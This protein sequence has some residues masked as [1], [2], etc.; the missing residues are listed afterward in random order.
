MS[1]AEEARPFISVI[2]PHL[3]QPEFLKSCLASLAR[4]TYQRCS[5]EVVVV[6]NGSRELP[7]WVGCGGDNITLDREAIPGPGPARNRGVAVS[8]GEVLAFIDA[9]CTADARWLEA[10]SDVLLKSAD[11]EIVGGDVRIAYD[12]P[13]RLTMIE[14]YETVFA[15]RQKEYIEKKGFSGTGNLMVRRGDFERIGLFAGIE[16]AEDRDW[17]QRAVAAGYR[18]VYVPDGIIYHPARRSLDEIKVKWRR[19]TDHDYA[20]WLRAG[21]GK[22]LWCAR[23]FAVAVSP[24]VDLARIARSDR[25]SGPQA[26]CLA[27][28]ALF[29]IRWWRAGRMLAI[30]SL[31]RPSLSAKAWNR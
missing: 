17:G 18:I 1:N 2:V 5:F 23:A 19:H 20:E 28:L 9:D 13:E 14:A 6:D 7:E 22:A 11:R 30:A 3:N 25:L 21:R 10:M 15:Y 31:R 12:D 24:I 27:A 8:H 16:V 4:Q 29:R 26:R